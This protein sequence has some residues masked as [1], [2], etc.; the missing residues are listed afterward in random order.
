MALETKDKSIAGV[1][2]RVTQLTATKGRAVFVRLAKLFAGMAGAKNMED[3]IAGIL[4]KLS[5]DDLK[6]VCDVFASATQVHAPG[7]KGWPQLSDVFDLHFAGRYLEMFQ[8]LAFCLEVNF[9][10]FFPGV[11]IAGLAQAA[12]S[13]SI[14]PK[15]AT[16]SSG[17]S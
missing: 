2:Y 17:G 11:D 3:R 16:G 6:F 8:W 12:T 10:G 4:G 7:D 5:D 13:G 14:S 9:S 15:G 1:T